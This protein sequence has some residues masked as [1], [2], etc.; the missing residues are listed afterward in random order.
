[1]L[2][3]IESADSGSLQR[4]IGRLIL[5]T[6]HLTEALASTET[7]FATVQLSVLEIEETQDALRMSEAQY[8]ELFSNMSDCVVVYEPVDEGQDFVFKDVNTAA[9]EIDRL[10][11]EEMVGRRVADVLPGVK[12]FGLMDVL[13]SV[14]RTGNPEHLPARRY[15][16]QRISSWREGFVYRLS[17]GDVVAVYKDVTAA[18]ER[19]HELRSRERFQRALLASI[20]SP[21]FYKDVQGRYL[22]CNKAFEELLGKSEQEISGKTSHEVSPDQFPTTF[23]EQDLALVGASGQE[24]YE[25]QFTDAQGRPRDLVILRSVFEGDDGRAAGIVGVILDLTDR[26]RLET[27]LRHAQKLEAV[28]QLAAGIAHEINTPAQF[29]GDSVQFLQEAH[30]SNQALI[31]AYRKALTTLL[32]TPGHETLARE[33]REAEEAADSAYVEEHAPGAFERALD[34][35]SRISSLVGAMKEFGHRD[36]REKSPADLNRALS[37]TLIVARNEYK[38]VADV[39]TEFGDIPLVTCYVSDLNQVFLNLLV[40][41]AHAIEDATGKGGPRGLITV[42]TALEEDRVRIDVQD[43]GCGIPPEVRDRVFE[44]FFTTKEVGRGTGQ[45]LAIAHS[46]VVD[47]HQGSLSFT[48]EPGRGTTFT[49]RLPVA[50]NHAPEPAKGAAE[51]VSNHGL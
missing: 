1:M 12:E 31:A 49:I 34:G 30:Q 15:H 33:I 5:L 27:D 43:T 23:R 51:E 3:E 44:P 16:D 26:R 38:Y 41:A 42:R 35:I 20:P 2:T 21:V 14:H 46:I 36:Q 7:A 28:G 37:T 13:K 10:G 11:R 39:A 50:A 32:A 47:R 4:L 24:Q 45:G 25:R 6:D 48:S 17:T 8:S 22:G 19:E 40:N 9:L 18:R 29:V